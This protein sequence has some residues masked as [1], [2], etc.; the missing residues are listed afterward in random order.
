MCDDC[1]R[2]RNPIFVRLF[3]HP[4]RTLLDAIVDSP[5]V[6]EG[7]MKITLR[8]ICVTNLKEMHGTT[9]GETMF[10]SPRTCIPLLYSFV[11]TWPHPIE[12]RMN[13][14]E[15]LRHHEL[16]DEK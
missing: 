11:S 2:F 3:K 14:F 13:A 7:G 4:F 1:T 16:L 15:F 8:G 12:T 9:I 5:S 6:L 10:L